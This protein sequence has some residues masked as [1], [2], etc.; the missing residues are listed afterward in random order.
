MLACEQFLFL[1]GIS[2]NAAESTFNCPLFLLPVPFDLNANR[3][4]VKI[5]AS[6]AFGHLRLPF[7]Y[8]LKSLEQRSR[9]RPRQR[10]PEWALVF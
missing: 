7:A 3:H 6:M 8:G 5:A 2:A 4:Q 1:Q 10:Q 9:P